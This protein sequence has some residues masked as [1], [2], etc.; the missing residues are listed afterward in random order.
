MY[1]Y[2][3]ERHA[4]LSW[5]PIAFSL[6]NNLFFLSKI[7][8]IFF[9]S[10]Q[11]K[12]KRS[13]SHTTVEVTLPQVE[14][15]NITPTQSTEVD[16]LAGVD[17][18]GP[19]WSLPDQPEPGPI[20]EEEEDAEHEEEEEYRDIQGHVAGNI[21]QHCY[22]QFWREELQPDMWTARVRAE[23]YKLSFI[24]GKWPDAYEEPNNK[25]AVDNAPFAWQQLMDWKDKGVTVIVPDKPRCVS[26]LT[27]SLREME[28]EVKK[29][30]CLDLSRHINKLI[31]KE[32][33]KLASLDKALEILLP[34]D[35]QAAYDLA[36]AY[37]HV[38][39]HPD[40]QTLLG[41]AVPHPDTGET[42]YFVFTCMP[43]G[44]STATHVLTRMTKPICVYITKNGIRHS[45]FIDDGKVNAESKEL[46]IWAFKFVLT[47]LRRAGFVISEKKSDSEN[48]M[49]QRKAYL[50][51]EIDSKDMTVRAK[52]QKIKAV[53]DNIKKIIKNRRTEAKKLAATIG[54]IISLEPALGP[55]VQLMTR[56]AQMDLAE[57]VQQRGW[58]AKLVMSQLTK[59]SLED[60][61]NS[62]ES[63]NG[64][65][66]RTRA[67]AT[68]IKAILDD[69]RSDKLVFGIKK[70]NMKQIVAGDAS[71]K[72]VCA[73]GV[74]G[75]PNLFFQAKLTEKE[76]A[77]SSGHRELL[78][79]KYTL[80]QKGELLKQL[81]STTILWLT[82]ST[83]MEAFLT[84]GSTKKSIMPD[85]LDTFKAARALNLRILPI[86]ISRNDYRLQAADHGTRFFDPDDWAI[87][88][89]SFRQ[90]T[91][92]S[93]WKPSIDTFA[94]FTNAKT[95]R[96]YS[97]G[98]SPNTQGVDAFAQ[99]WRGE[100]AWVCPPTSLIIQAVKKIA[101]TDMKAVLITPAWPT[102]AFW[103]FIF[104]DGKRAHE[105]IERAVLFRPH[106]IRGKFCTNKLL[107][108]KTSFP[109]LAAY[110]RS[111]GAGYKHRAGKVQDPMMKK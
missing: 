52:P 67:T 96:F 24:D 81:P 71:D 74:Q 106:V 90:L 36:S 21:H 69:C 64:A 16:V 4:V 78:T 58:R 94:H 49:S 110:I 19:E 17:I 98:K 103:S 75:I 72:A 40:Y 48:T 70:H 15:V 108:G 18:A 3:P 107:Q 54:K 82:D 50:G 109:F 63:F 53:E 43:F 22:D 76:K 10:S 61:A 5:S 31:K 79:V 68:P 85:I 87:D 89:E 11:K 30:L 14:M 28:E 91:G 92:R 8:S 35:M 7:A 105:L 57:A 95:D 80:Q 73:Y 23:G 34:G 104:P 65:T 27:V 6:A 59:D 44:L 93:E 9:P 45:I 20:T 33:V 42:V 83:N 2:L 41:C 60:F 77:L 99:S 26:P 37:H 84:K 55:I 12:K 46:L 111:T 1:I 38:K 13:S 88:F 100:T 56:A 102:A 101:A 29:R 66:I 32:Q 39:I 51:F 62:M 25:S 97:Y 86:Q 47:T